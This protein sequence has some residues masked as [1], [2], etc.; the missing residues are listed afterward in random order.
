MCPMHHFIQKTETKRKKA[1]VAMSSFFHAWK[2]AEN[3]VMITNLK[4]KTAAMYCAMLC[5]CRA[6]K[7]EGFQ[8]EER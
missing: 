3:V 8:V 2:L 6:N 7:K 1:T 4:S 5:C